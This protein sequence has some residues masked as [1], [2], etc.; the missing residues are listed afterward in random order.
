[1]NII[2]FFPK[3]WNLISVWTI[4]ERQKAPMGRNQIPCIDVAFEK[5]SGLPCFC[6]FF[7]KYI[8]FFLKEKMIIAVVF[9]ISTLFSEN[10]SPVIALKWLGIVSPSNKDKQSKDEFYNWEWLILL[11]FSP[12]GISDNFNLHPLKRYYIS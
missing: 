12:F 5:W 7:N 9:Y 8:F 11:I 2:S 3:F 1:M 4:L 10:R 6:F